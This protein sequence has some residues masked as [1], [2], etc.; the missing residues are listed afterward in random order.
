MPLVFMAAQGR[1]DVVQEGKR[2]LFSCPALITRGVSQLPFLSMLHW[3]KKMGRR[4]ILRNYLARVSPIPL[5]ENL[6]Q[7]KHNGVND[8]E[9]LQ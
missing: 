8:E 1:L 6:G 9:C 4:S 7:R 3:G 5:S 2:E